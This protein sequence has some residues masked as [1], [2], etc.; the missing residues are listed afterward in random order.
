MIE[1][2]FVAIGLL[3]DNALV[4]GATIITIRIENIEDKCCIRIDDNGKN[5]WTEQEIIKSILTFGAQTNPITVGVDKRIKKSI[6]K[7]NSLHEFGSNLKLGCLRL[8]KKFL[9]VS[10]ANK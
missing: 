6:H 7:T 8:G 1:F 2:P 4:Q 10:N 5:L 3:T 9:Y